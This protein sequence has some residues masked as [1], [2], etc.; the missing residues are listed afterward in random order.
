[1]TCD[2]NVIYTSLKSIFSGLQFRHSHYG[3]VFIRLAVVTVFEIFML[4]DRKL[5]ILLTPPLFDA[6]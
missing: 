2:I 3:S 6:S 4:K 5:L 1:M